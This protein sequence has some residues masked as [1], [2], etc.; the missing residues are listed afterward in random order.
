M[1]KPRLDLPADLGAPYSPPDD[2]TPADL[3]ALADQVR[4]DAEKLLSED[5]GITN[6][7][8][9]IAQ[10]NWLMDAVA[11][12]DD[13]RNA[14]AA[15]EK[16]VADA[17]A[18]ARGRLAPA[19]TDPEGGDGGD[20]TG[21][22]DDA[23]LT[24]EQKAA[25]AKAKAEADA[26]AGGG[27]GN[28][29]P[30]APPEPVLVASASV[31]RRRS[32]IAAAA[33]G[34]GNQ[35]KPVAAGKAREAH[36]VAAAEV[37]GFAAG[38][39]ISWPEMGQAAAK[40]FEQLPDP[41]GGNAGRVVLPFGSVR[42]PSDERLVAS[43][44]SATVNKRG[45]RVIDLD[46]AIEWA[47]SNERLKAETGADSLVAAGGWC[48]PSETLYDLINLSTRDGM[49]DVAG[50]TVNRGGVR[51]SLGPDYTAVYNA[52]INFTRT[53][54]QTIAGTPTKP[55]VN[56]PCPTWTD[57]RMVVD[58]LYLTADILTQKGF[59][60]GIADYTE[61][62]LIAFAHY[63]NAATLSDMETLS[64]TLIDLTVSTATVQ[65]PNL[66]VSTELL[67]AVE[68]QVTDMRYKN[69]L[70]LNNSVELI[71]P[72]WL[73]GALRSDL[74]K[75]QGVEDAS[76]LPDS[77]IEAFFAQRGASIQWVYDWQDAFT[78][79]SGGFGG[80]TPAVAWPISAK[81]MIHPT[82]TFVRALSDVIEL[83]AVYDAQLLTTNQYVALFMEQAR[84]TLKRA[85][86]ARVV[87][88]PVVVSGATGGPI[89]YT[90]TGRQPTV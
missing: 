35:S 30:V 88:V 9:R 73:K 57:N 1:A 8:E 48:A 3:Q 76:N 40:R 82:G 51:Y 38:Q 27:E 15:D 20:G 90:V 52:G 60:E 58:G 26:A 50:I 69:R 77:E 47:L 78:G 62:S 36:L 22:D 18:E 13:R 4:L 5:N 87:K 61:K 84:L 11:A 65:Q 63:V 54:A 66:A 14:I 68:L 32:A 41:M 24:D 21:D 10:A 49:V 89:D 80:A 6:A 64:G 79:V 45:E 46:E 17:L 67:G 81:F 34:G 39:A 75:R 53:E 85:W 31:A 28:G 33:T 86:D 42:I 25:K 71:F 37:G 12:M 19:Q 83:S 43:A 74:A 55:M 44:R 23:N 7:N 70:S 16:A 59:P 56:I 72:L 2:A 29:A